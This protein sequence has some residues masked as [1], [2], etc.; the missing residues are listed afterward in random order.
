MLEHAYQKVL[1]D[2][3]KS[4]K[5]KYQEKL[6]AVIN[7]PDSTRK[8]LQ[9]EINGLDSKSDMDASRKINYLT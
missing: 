2:N 9:E 3:K 8:V 1:E 5:T 6:D 4:E 7:M